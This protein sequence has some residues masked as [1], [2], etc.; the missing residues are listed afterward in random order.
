MGFFFWENKVSL[1][2]EEP[3]LPKGDEGW[4]IKHP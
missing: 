4:E 1:S 2:D 3:E